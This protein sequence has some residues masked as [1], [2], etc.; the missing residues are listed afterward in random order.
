M[1][2]AFYGAAR[3]VTGSQY[4]LTAGKSRVL[5]D[6]GMFQGSDHMRVQNRMSFHFKPCELDAV[7]LTHA[8]ID[9][10]GLLPRLVGDGFCGRV[11]TTDATGDLIEIMLLDSAYIQ[12]EDAEWD[13]KKWIRQGRI[14]PPP[15]PL[16]TRDDVPPTLD[17]L[18]SV[19]YWKEQDVAPG[20]RLRFNDAG[21]ILG[22]AVVEV[23][24]EEG[25]TETKLVF[26][27]DLGRP[28][29]S[30]MRDPETVTEADYLI[31]ESTYGNR[32]HHPAPSD[33][34]EFEQI[35]IDNYKR[36]GHLIIPA[37][38][39]GRT[40]EVLY[41]LN[42][43]I[44]SG[45][46]KPHRVYLD[47]PLGIKATEIVRSHREL[48]DEESLALLAAGDKPTEFKGLEY[49]HTV[50]ESKAINFDSGP[51]IVIAGSGMCTAGRVR[52]HLYN[53]L[54]DPNATVLIVGFQ[55]MGTLGRV[56]VEKA[57]EVK[58]FG[59]YIPVNARIESLRGL[60]AHADLGQLL[61]WAEHISGLKA[62][63][64]THGEETAALDFTAA[65]H[66]R[67]DVPTYAPEAG[68]VAELGPGASDER[69]RAE[70]EQIW[71]REPSEA[72]QMVMEGRT[73]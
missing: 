23:W 37:F 60:S 25:Q 29:Q 36:H 68:F 47:S 24:V 70:A 49:S 55:A 1:H 7:I 11:F 67:L 8:H 26:S 71:L 63:F 4:L 50:D 59:E 57:K 48:F 66:R 21:H 34:A 13:R 44:E 53:H 32:V 58:L 64:V 19:P 31:I 14:G 9:H 20:V 18:R 38:A 46:V 42:R 5:I 12:E 27:G 33:Y 40:Q 35:V 28:G 56:L 65:L 41:A 15:Q 30:L 22:S 54:A 17:L 52:H 10:S 73:G 39:V 62:A 69:W 72:E 16:Y 6:C 43:L 3:T 45:R 51:C 2:L 61:A